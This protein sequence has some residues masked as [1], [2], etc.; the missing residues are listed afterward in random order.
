[1]PRSHGH[2]L[3]SEAQ[4]AENRD[5]RG[6]ACVH[7]VDDLGAVAALQVDRPDAEVGV[8]A[9]ALDDDQRHALA[10]HLDGVGVSQLMGREAPH[11]GLAGDVSQLGAAAAAAQGAGAWVR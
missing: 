11:A 2:V 5:H 10:R 9:L 1:M 7:G 6:T 4:P 8:A 3:T